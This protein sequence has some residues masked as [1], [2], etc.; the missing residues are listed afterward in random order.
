MLSAEVWTKNPAMVDHLGLH[1][2]LNS[3][4]CNSQKYLLFLLFP[5]VFSFSRR[6]DHAVPLPC[7]WPCHWRGGAK[8]FELQSPSELWE[9]R[10]GGCGRGEEVWVLNSSLEIGVGEAKGWNTKFLRKDFRASVSLRKLQKCRRL[11]DLRAGGN[12]EKEMRGRLRMKDV[13]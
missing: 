1:I 3:S 11:R 12:F 10:E 6:R 5:Q 8:G 4:S 7:P 9:A 2:S 13:S